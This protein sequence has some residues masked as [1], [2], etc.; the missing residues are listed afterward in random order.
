M[1]LVVGALLLLLPVAI[2]T[3][4][5]G[6][7]EWEGTAAPSERPPGNYIDR[8]QVVNVD[9]LQYFQPAFAL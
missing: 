8:R 4:D 5:E 2:V 6:S 3:E 9:N 1:L 7:G